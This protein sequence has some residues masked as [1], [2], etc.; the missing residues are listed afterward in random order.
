MNSIQKTLAPYPN[1]LDGITLYEK[2]DPVALNKLIHSD[3]LMTTEWNKGNGFINYICHNEKQQLE[4]YYEKCKNGKVPVTYKKVKGNP[5]G[6]SD[7]EKSLSL[8]T[9]RQ[10]IRH[11]ICKTFYVDVDIC[12]CHPFGSYC[13]LWSGYFYLS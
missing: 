4:K 13:L 8:F 9:I 6:R 12:N 7:P 1:I 5:F 10:E 2:I 11:T 3:L